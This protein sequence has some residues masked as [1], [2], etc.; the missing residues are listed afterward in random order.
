[1]KSLYLPRWIDIHFQDKQTLAHEETIRRKMV[2]V[3]EVR[4]LRRNGFSKRERLP[5][6]QDW[7]I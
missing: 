5:D 2:L 7:P 3:E 4:E 6:E 1:M